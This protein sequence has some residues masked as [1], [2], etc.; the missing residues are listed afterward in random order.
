[1]RLT[2]P[3]KRHL[4]SLAHPLKPCVTV[5]AAGVTPTVLREL[6]GALAHHELL[7]VRFRVGDR[8]AR[9]EAVATLAREAGALVLGRTGHVAIMYRR[10][11]EQP[12]IALP[13]AGDEPA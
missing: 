1:M 4:R 6:D 5:G 9:D 10:N 2:G 12:R 8:E 3:Q 7:K 11:E 13:P